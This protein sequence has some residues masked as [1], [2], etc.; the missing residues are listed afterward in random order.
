MTLR[1]RAIYYFFLTIYFAIKLWSQFLY[2]IQYGLEVSRSLGRKMINFEN[3]YILTINQN[4]G[5]KLTNSGGWNAKI[6][7]IKILIWM[8]NYHPNEKLRSRSY[9]S[10]R[11]NLSEVSWPLINIEKDSTKV[12][13]PCI[14]VNVLI[15]IPFNSRVSQPKKESPHKCHLTLSVDSFLVS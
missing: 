7:L 8:S 10:P 2:P 13:I 12:T 15:L 5:Y 11:K 1:T 14:S 9:L 6:T 4:L 3:F